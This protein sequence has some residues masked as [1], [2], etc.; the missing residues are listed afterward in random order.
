MSRMLASRPS[1]RRFIG[2][3]SALV[4][5]PFLMPTGTAAR[6]T[7]FEL[8]DDPTLST[9]VQTSVGGPSPAGA[10]TV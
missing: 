7:G 4:A 2:A 3:T 9:L 8:S 5:A 6:Q 10:D 1:R